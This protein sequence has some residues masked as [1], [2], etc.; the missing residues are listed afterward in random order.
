M[1]KRNEEEVFVCA[2]AKE[3]NAKCNAMQCTNGTRR[4]CSSARAPRMLMYIHVNLL[5]KI[6][7]CGRERC[8]SERVDFARRVVAVARGDGETAKSVLTRRHTTPP[9]LSLSPPPRACVPREVALDV[10]GRAIGVQVV[11]VDKAGQD[12]GDP[13]LVRASAGV[14]S[15]AGAVATHALLPDG[16]RGQVVA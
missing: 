13:V 10:A 1:Y 11:T 15:G 9:S 16:S 14:I 2:R 12:K 6:R 7:Y 3:V 4:K 5:F 8:S